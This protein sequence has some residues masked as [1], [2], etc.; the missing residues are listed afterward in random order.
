MARRKPEWM[1]A[2]VEATTPTEVQRA[3]LDVVMVRVA[4]NVRRSW[5]RV[6]SAPA[7]SSWSVEASWER[8]QT[9]F[10]DEA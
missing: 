7:A 3:S 6:L 10:S 5:G 8:S 4:R 2:G 1:A 9:R